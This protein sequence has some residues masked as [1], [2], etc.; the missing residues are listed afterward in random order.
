ML[1][2]K[3]HP[4][5]E[6]AM[7]IAET[8]RG[9]LSR[10]GL[11]H[12]AKYRDYDE[13]HEV[14]FSQI[15]ASPQFVRLRIDVDLLPKMV[16]TA[17][18]KSDEVLGDLGHTLG[19]PVTFEDRDKKS[20]CWFVVHLGELDGIPNRV[21]FSQFLNSYPAGAVPMTIPIGAGLV[22][23]VWR[24]LR[25]MPHLLIAGATGKGKSVMVHAIL[26]TLLHIPP[27][28]LRLILADLK[29]GMTL[30]KYKKVPHLSR[31]HYCNRAQDLPL[32]L[33]ALQAEMQRRA[34]AMENIAEDIDE[35]NRV[36]AQKWPYILVVIEELANAMLSRRR[37]KLPDG[38]RLTVGAA[39]E[40]LLADLAA[41]ARATGIHIVVTTQTPRSDVISGIIKANF[42]V[43]LAF[44]TASDMDSRVIIDN[45]M[46]QGL[47]PG[48]MAF[49]DCSEITVL[50]APLMGEDDLALVIKKTLA[51]EHWLAGKTKE[52]LLAEHVHLVLEVGWRDFRGVL[53]IEKLYRAPDIKKQRMTPE[54]ITEC[55]GILVVD[56]AVRKMAFSRSYRIVLEESEWRKKYHVEP[57]VL[58]DWD[59]SKPVDEEGVIEGEVVGSKTTSKPLQMLLQ[60]PQNQST[61]ESG[62]EAS[63]SSKTG[64][65][66]D[67]RRWDSLG[68]SRNEMVKRMGMDKTKA[69]RVI[70]EVL[71]SARG[72]HG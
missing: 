69:L 30:G 41:R 52:Y 27:K 47:Q 21:E 6:Q 5:E 66:E 45:S 72:V 36:R 40:E 61:D 31:E 25:E 13:L 24:N 7:E 54:R 44:G 2:R 70:T 16:T 50:Q 18:L 68:Y 19:H 28:R 64:F 10:M 51:G 11:A 55:I 33:M 15:E 23:P 20:G 63:Q 60:A 26:S 71:G 3:R 56:G 32:V 17:R 59:A 34:E 35:W 67:I 8:V 58:N 46:A 48:R 39:T 1:L 57:L 49:L 53:D 4:L 38:T 62:F 22:G 14:T 43:R 12:R 29:G 9:K 42:P 37:I 65:E